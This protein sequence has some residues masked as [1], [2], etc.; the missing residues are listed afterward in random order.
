MIEPNAFLRDAVSRSVTC[1]PNN[2]AAAFAA[3]DHRLFRFSR[4]HR[5]LANGT[6]TGL[7]GFGERHHGQ[8]LYPP[9]IESITDF[10]LF[11]RR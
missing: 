7:S 9:E 2:S 5:H 1:D 8:Y 3:M 4:L 11:G 6:W 10:Y